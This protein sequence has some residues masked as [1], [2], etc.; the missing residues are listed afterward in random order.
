[1]QQETFSRILSE[2]SSVFQRL[3]DAA[4]RRKEKIETR[5][6]SEQRMQEREARRLSNLSKVI[7]P[8]SRAM[9]EISR[10]NQDVY[11]RLYEEARRADAKKEEGMSRAAMQKEQQMLL[12]RPSEFD[13]TRV[14][15][16]FQPDIGP[17]ARKCHR[18]GKLL[19]R[20]D[21]HGRLKQ[22]EIQLRDAVKRA[23]VMEGCTFQPTIT[24]RSKQLAEKANRRHRSLH[25]D[26][27]EGRLQV[28]NMALMRRNGDRSPRKGSKTE[29][30]SLNSSETSEEGSWQAFQ[31]KNG[32][33]RLSFVVH[34]GAGGVSP[35]T[36]N[37][38]PRKAY[39]SCRGVDDVPPLLL[40][41]NWVQVVHVTGCDGVGRDEG[42][43]EG[44]GLRRLEN[45]ALP[46]E[47]HEK[48]QAWI[49]EMRRKRDEKEMSECTFQP[50][51]ISNSSAIS[52][53]ILKGLI[54]PLEN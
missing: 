8:R 7:N 38:S 17:A 16:P 5:L 29:D 3:Y 27:Y 2:Q 10:G 1:L 32:A 11:S 14:L 20:L 30:C 25:E 46:R 36:L 43:E 33:S 40:K 31:N 22:Q 35:A 24:S 15:E 26:L 45:L 51:L 39:P 44:G 50:H 42:G 37:V 52:K 21:P 12:E 19:E 18:K 23:Q 48:R 6:T 49:L 54:Q 9:A 34:E 28:G 41:N 4:E 53:L 47:R 13:K